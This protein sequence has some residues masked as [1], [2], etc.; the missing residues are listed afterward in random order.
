MCTRTH[1]RLHTCVHVDRGAHGAHIHTQVNVLLQR[2]FGICRP[3][4]LAQIQN[5]SDDLTYFPFLKLRTL[6]ADAP[7]RSPIA[8][9][10]VSFVI[11][12]GTVLRAKEGSWQHCWAAR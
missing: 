1:A 2:C 9:V 6:L 12:T 3:R 4:A 10:T 11:Q 5:P 7:R 8:R